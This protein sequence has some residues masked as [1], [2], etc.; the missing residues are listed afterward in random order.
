MERVRDPVQLDRAVHREVRAGA[1]R[2]LAGDLDVH[3]HRALAHR[4]V[5]P[6]D[7]ALHDPVPGVHQRRL[8]G[9]DVARLRLGD[10]QHRLEFPGV[11]NPCEVRSRA[12]LLADLDRHLQQGSA[13]SGPHREG[14]ELPPAE[15][16]DRPVT[17]D[18]R[19]LGGDL[20][21]AGIGEDGE[22]LLFEPVAGFQFLGAQLA[23]PVDQFPNQPRLEELAVGIGAAARLG[24]G[25]GELAG[26]V[27]LLQQVG[28]RLVEQ[29]PEL[30][31]LGA[32][33][34]FGLPG[35][36][37]EFG[38]RENQQYGVL[39]D[40]GSGEH[41][42]LLDPPAGLGGQPADLFG[43]DLEGARSPDLPDQFAPFDDA[44]PDDRAVHLGRAGGDA[45]EQQDHDQQRGGAA[46][47][48]DQSP[49]T[50]FPL[51]VGD[52]EVHSASLVL[53]RRRVPAGPGSGT[54]YRSRAAPRPPGS[55]GTAPRRDTPPRAAA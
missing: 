22:A 52:L 38:I 30:R 33:L 26:R 1:A 23:P 20:R 7:D 14:G 55:A 2:K 46:A 28:A 11:R 41:A 18:G 24:G 40:R 4:G 31:L 16:Q 12:H 37:F 39:L 13:A 45:A 25:S 9:F 50:A 54:G 36:L 3:G 21:R 34:E 51:P 43:W 42:P 48:Q 5:H 35:L 53:S 29:P 32:E 10:P 47:G 19:L 8:A 17:R 27:S 6:G 15:F 49:D 44:G